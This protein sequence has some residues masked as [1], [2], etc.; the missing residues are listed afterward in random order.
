MSLKAMHHDG[1]DYLFDNSSAEGGNQVQHLARVLDPHTFR[2]LADVGVRGHWLDI[3]AGLGTV[4]QF[5]LDQGA[6]VVAV[7]IDPSPLRRLGGDERFEVVHGDIRLVSLGERRYA[8]IHA[9]LVFQHLSEV[10]RRDLLT[11]LLR[12]LVPGGALVLS[13][14]AGTGQDLVRR[15]PSPQATALLDRFQRV[16]MGIIA[17]AGADMGWGQRTLAAMVDA[18][19][20]DVATYYDSR[21]Y[22]GGTGICLLHASNSRQLE[23]QFLAAG[24]TRAELE[25]L[26]RLLADPDV[27]LSSYLMCTTVGYRPSPAP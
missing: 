16:L 10:E 24:M 26:R 23:G 22:R 11:V 7:D 1:P 25:E 9:R 5:L 21:T 2:V 19:F 17:A 13:D 4:S 8:G 27:T 15:S 12:A 3:G 18:G 20:A 14:W 6:H